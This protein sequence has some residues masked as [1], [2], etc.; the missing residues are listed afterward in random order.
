MSHCCAKRKEEDICVL[1]YMYVIGWFI[2]CSQLIVPCCP[3][4]FTQQPFTVFTLLWCALYHG[5]KGCLFDLF[6]RLLTS[7]ATRLNVIMHSC[8]LGVFNCCVFL[9]GSL[10]SN[11][12]FGFW[13]TLIWG[14]LNGLDNQANEHIPAFDSVHCRS[15]SAVLSVITGKCTRHLGADVSHQLPQHLA[16]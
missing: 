4:R 3:P 8:L 12:Q 1:I 7:W 6:F 11:M 5:W 14:S 10:I 15:L 9:S 16:N 2:A 13:E